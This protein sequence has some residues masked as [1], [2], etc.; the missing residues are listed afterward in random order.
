M[1]NTVLAPPP[2]LEGAKIFVFFGLFFLKICAIFDHRLEFW[3]DS[4]STDFSAFCSTSAPVF[5]N[6]VMSFIF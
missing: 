5:G 4:A 2:T 3:T 1:Q 6:S